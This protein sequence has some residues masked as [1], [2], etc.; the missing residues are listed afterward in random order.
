MK[1]LKSPTKHVVDRV[2]KQ[3][4]NTKTQQ[5]LTQK[6]IT[7][8]DVLFY[9]MYKDIFLFW[10]FFDKVSG[11]FLEG[12][13]LLEFQPFTQQPIFFFFSIISYLFLVSFESSSSL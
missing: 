4:N 1:R 11:S 12:K 7:S 10:M 6:I 2:A 3:K 9:W 5:K 13:K 8:K